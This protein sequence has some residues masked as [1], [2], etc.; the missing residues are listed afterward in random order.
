[1][2]YF[3]FIMKSCLLFIGY[4]LICFAAKLIILLPMANSMQG[5]DEGFYGSLL[6]TLGLVWAFLHH[7]CA[8]IR[9]L[10]MDVHVAIEKDSARKTATSV[11]V[12]S[13]VLT[14]LVALKLFGV[15]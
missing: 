12:V 7:F 6:I 8:G 14:A 15:F 9:H 10:F 4:L 11:L 3:D 13:V 5:G 1:M 2:N